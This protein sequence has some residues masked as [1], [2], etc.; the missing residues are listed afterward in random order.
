MTE[1]VLSPAVIASGRDE[2]IGKVNAVK[3][4]VSRIHI[5]IMDGI[6]VKQESNWFPFS[7]PSF[8]G[9]YE[10]HLMVSDPAS[11]LKRKEAEHFDI[12]VIHAEIGSHDLLQS[13]VDAIKK[14][15]K[16]VFLALN[17]E[18]PW[19]NYLDLLHKIN[20]V[21]VMC[22]HPGQYSATFILRMLEK[23]RSLRQHF[24]SLFIQVD[25]GMNEKNILLAKKAGANGF[26]VGGRIFKTQDPLKALWD[27]EKVVGK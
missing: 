16:E 10:A 20:G 8:K 26:I 18:T 24:P 14:K 23:V 13:V 7:L 22:V 17:P 6:F 27:L 3:K 5:D 11:W 12:L 2:M 21:Q 4:E 15:K 1:Y 25:G 9:E 19:E